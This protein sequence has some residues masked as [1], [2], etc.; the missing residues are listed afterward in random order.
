MNEKLENQCVLCHKKGASVNLSGIKQK[1]PSYISKEG[2]AHLTCLKAKV[3]EHFPYTEYRLFTLILAIG[4]F[5]GVHISIET[6]LSG[7]FSLMNFLLPIMAAS[8]LLFLYLLMLNFLSKSRRLMNWIIKQQKAGVEL[9]S[10]LA[11]SCVLCEEKELNSPKKLKNAEGIKFDL[12]SI[13]CLLPKYLPKKGVVHLDCLEKVVPDSKAYFDGFKYYIDDYILMVI[14][15]V[16][17]LIF[18]IM[19]GSF[20]YQ[21]YVIHGVDPSRFP[22]YLGIM[23]VVSILVVASFQFIYCFTPTYHLRKWIKKQHSR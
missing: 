22:L 13:P 2:H 20:V 3:Y 23:I 18:S 12:L 4:Y 14:L 16:P 17:M 8:L 11:S 1:L 9:E 15:S 5:T 10:H 7:T 6:F 19:I 21:Y